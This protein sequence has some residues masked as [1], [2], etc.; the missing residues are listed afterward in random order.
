MDR[1]HD[2]KRLAKLAGMIS[3]VNLA[4]LAKACAAHQATLERLSDLE[5]SGATDLDPLAEA[6]A[7]LRY[8]MWADQRRAEILPLLK[9]QAEAIIRAQVDSRFA[10]GRAQILRE[11]TDKGG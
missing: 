5:I 11:L 10:F 3:D 9:S 6:R 8:E 2:L 7:N 4:A 1:S